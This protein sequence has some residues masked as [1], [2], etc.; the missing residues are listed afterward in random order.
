[1]FSIIIPT[2]FKSETIWRTLM[3]LSR[4]NVVGEII[5]IDN[6]ENQKAYKLDKLNHVL[7]GTNIFVNPAWNKGVNLSQYENICLLNDDIYFDWSKLE[8]IEMMLD[9][10]TGF[11]GMHPFNFEGE[12]AENSIIGLHR[13]TPYYDPRSSRGHRPE[14]WGSCIFFNRA[15]WDPIPEVLKI[16]AGDDWLFYRSNKRNWC[17]AGLKCHGTHS[18]TIESMDVKSIIESDMHHMSNFI[19]QG[20]CD[21]YLRGTIWDRED[22]STN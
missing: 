8:D 7:N 12:L 9:D 3:D 4:I 16:W 15:N 2:M 21:N 22:V 1:M 11:M 20:M 17:L 5:L 19:K 18:K 6:S 13:T 14:K 10:N